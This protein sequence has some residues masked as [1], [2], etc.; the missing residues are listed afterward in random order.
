LKTKIDNYDF[1]GRF[2]AHKKLYKKLGNWSYK[3]RGDSW[4]KKALRKL[5][6]QI[7]RLPLTPNLRYVI[8]T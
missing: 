7:F 4:H 6:C 3:V 8:H 1:K 2:D 5:S